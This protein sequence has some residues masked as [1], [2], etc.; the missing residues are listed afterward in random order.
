MC[1]WQIPH[2][3]HC[4]VGKRKCKHDREEVRKESH[5]TRRLPQIW[6]QVYVHNGILWRMYVSL[7]V[8]KNHQRYN[9]WSL[10][11]YGRKFW[12]SGHL[13]VDKTMEQLKEWFYWPG[14]HTDV[15]D[16]CWNCPTCSSRKSITY[17]F[18]ALLKSVIAGYPQQ[19]VA[20][21]I[22]GPFPKLVEG[23]R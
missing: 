4:C 22:V 20:V 21:D 9:K 15:S 17:R 2:R 18:R 10:N 13:G 3:G 11:H 12:V 23:N 7:N 19:I 5:Y 6:N 14:Y 1:S 16:W 8:L